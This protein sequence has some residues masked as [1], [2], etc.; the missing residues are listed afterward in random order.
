[1][2]LILLDLSEKAMRSLLTAPPM[3]VGYPRFELFLR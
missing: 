1:M 2:D 3:I